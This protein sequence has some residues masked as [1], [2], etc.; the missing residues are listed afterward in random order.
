M[1]EMT[2]ANQRTLEEIKGFQT[3]IE[4]RQAETSEMQRIAEDRL[5]KQ[6]EEWQADQEKR[7]QRQ[8]LAWSGQWQEHDRLHE[9]WEA[10]L[11]K[12][13]QILP[14]YARQFKVVWDGL[15]EISKLYLST[16]RQLVEAQ[17]AVLEK[18]RPSRA[19][20]SGNNQT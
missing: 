8:M 20:L 2:M 13:E 17:Q 19:V 18:G 15:E 3:R 10:R 6:V 16:A 4:S 14:E 11:E 12:T 1:Q 5:K 7:W 9:S